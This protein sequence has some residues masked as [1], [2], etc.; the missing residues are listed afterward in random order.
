MAAPRKTLVRDAEVDAL[1]ARYRATGTTSERIDE[2]L[3][4][5][6]RERAS[7]VRELR[8]RTPEPSWTEIGDLLGI[9]GERA[10]QLATEPTKETR[11]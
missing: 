3:A 9:S 10:R 6:T 7:V 4:A 8:A 1:V 5:M 2:L 11:Q